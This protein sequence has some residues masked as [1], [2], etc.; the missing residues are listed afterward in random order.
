MKPQQPNNN[1]NPTRGITAEDLVVGGKYVPH[2]KS[3]GD[4]FDVFKE[5]CSRRGESIILQ[6]CD[7]YDKDYWFKTTQNCIYRFSLSD[8]TPYHEPNECCHLECDD[9]P[10]TESTMME[11]KSLHEP[12]QTTN[13]EAGRDS[14]TNKTQ[15]MNNTEGGL[16]STPE[17]EIQP[18]N[19]ETALK[20]PEWVYFRNGEKP[21]EWH[22]F[23]RMNTESCI[24]AIHNGKYCTNNK[25]GFYNNDESG[26]AVDLILR[27][28]YVTKWFNVYKNTGYLSKEEADKSATLEHRIA[29][30]PVKIPATN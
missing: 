19:L 15:T 7:V 16:P 5:D 27:V 6:Y 3:I 4:S 8:L 1:T 24:I 10:Y 29:C 28:P 18:F 25:M 17:W 26:C 9:C 22:W 2:S 11:L 21:L 30:V 14:T 20:H 12:N 13:A 23:E